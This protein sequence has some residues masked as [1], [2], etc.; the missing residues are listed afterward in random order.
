M[1]VFLIED[2][3]QF[4]LHHKVMF[5]EQDV[6]VAVS[7]TEEAQPKYSSLRFCSFDRGFHSQANRKRLDE[8]LDLNALPRKGR[9]SKAVRE[10]ESEEDFVEARCQ[11]PVVESAINALDH[12]GLDRTRNYGAESFANTVVLS[13]LA[14]NMHR[15]GDL[16][17]KRERERRRRKRLKLAA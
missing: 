14:S 5:T 3:Y 10:R 15:L 16:L 17:R 4:I 7:I 13:I 6:D 2:Q 12:R 11:H 1:P 9:L 8:L